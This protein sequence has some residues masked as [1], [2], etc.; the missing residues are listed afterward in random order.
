MWFPR[1]DWALIYWD[2]IAMVFILR[3]TMI[4]RGLEDLE[5]ATIRP[6]DVDE[7][8]RRLANDAGFRAAIASDL[9]R[10]L[11]EDPS[12]LRARVIASWCD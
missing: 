6:D 5:Y 8:R 1:R 11:Q 10:K 7:I 3:E 2:D 12:C 9:D 4:S